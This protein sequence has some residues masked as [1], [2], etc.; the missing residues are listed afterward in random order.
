MADVIAQPVTTSG[1]MGPGNS[2]QIDNFPAGLATPARPSIGLRVKPVVL[3][4]GR[5]AIDVDNG[6][7]YRVVAKLLEQDARQVG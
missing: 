6:R 4:E 2:R 3:E 1:E 7:T 5:N